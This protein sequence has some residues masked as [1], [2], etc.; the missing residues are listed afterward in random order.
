[1]ARPRVACATAL[2]LALGLATACGGDGTTSEQLQEQPTA[3]ETTG[4]PS[5][6]TEHGA[7]ITIEGQEANNHGT[8]DVTALDDL[9]IEIHD[10]YFAPTVL[11]GEAGQ[12]LFIAL[13]NEGSVDH[14]FTIDELGIELQF[15]PD[16]ANGTSVTFPDSGMIVFYCRFHDDQGMRGALSVGS[17]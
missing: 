12:T 17:L 9:H 5:P 16:T 1:L 4:E 8:Q 10:Y 3:T 14:T 11:E 2:V 7:T 6:T 15:P 13:S